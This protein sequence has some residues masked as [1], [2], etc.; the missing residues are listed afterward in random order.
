MIKAGTWYVL[1]LIPVHHELDKVKHLVEARE[2]VRET[3]DV[4][5]TAKVCENLSKTTCEISS[6]TKTTY[7]N[8]RGLNMR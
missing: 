3:S 1:L 2:K 8:N 4:P 6:V 7:M 5:T